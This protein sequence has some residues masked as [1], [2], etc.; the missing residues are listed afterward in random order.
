MGVIGENRFKS[1]ESIYNLTKEEF[2]K[3]YGGS[4][5]IDFSNESIEQLQKL[6]VE[7]ENIPIYYGSHYSNPAYVC[8]YLTRLFPFSFIAIELQGN[9]FDDPNRMFRSI[10]KSF[11]SSSFIEL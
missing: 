3:E 9:N 10:S 11:E 7:M 2:I 4:I 1:Y 6:N 8:H 5:K